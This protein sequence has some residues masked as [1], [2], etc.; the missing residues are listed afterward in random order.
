MAEIKKKYKNLTQEVV[1]MYLKFCGPCQTK[2]SS[3]RKGLVVKPIIHSEMNS[4]CQVDLIDMQSQADGEFRFIMV[5]QDHLTKFV[6]LRALKSKTAEEVANNILDIFCIFGAPVILQS[7]NGREFVNKIINDL[8]IMWPTLKIVHGKPRHS[9]SQGSVERANQDIQNMLITWMQTNSVKSWKE[10]LRFVQLMKNKALHSGIQ[11][12]PY[13][14][15]FGTDMRV[16]LTTHFP[17]ESVDKINSEDDLEIFLNNINVEEDVNAK[18][19]IQVVNEASKDEGLCDLISIRQFPPANVGDS[20]RV[21]LP[22]VD[23]GRADPRNIL[24]AV[25]AIE[26]EQYY[27]LVLGSLLRTPGLKH[28]RNLYKCDQQRLTIISSPQ[29]CE[30]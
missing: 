5:Y 22:D 4:R 23:R 25:V 29:F 11:R 20:V 7:D 21:T 17:S 2:L 16:G 9:Q 1:L 12:S 8:K 6:Q 14:A 30:P 15:M 24:F 19:N 28:G 26:N 3:K 10:G 27:K 13:E 18:N